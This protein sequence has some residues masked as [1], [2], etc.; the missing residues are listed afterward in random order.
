MTDRQHLASW[1]LDLDRA[2]FA[3][4]L[5]ALGALLAAGWRPA[6]G[7][8]S[9]SAPAPSPAFAATISASPGPDQAR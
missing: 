8:G 4:A 2:R 6:L 3:Q 7:S 5:A 9:R 1:S